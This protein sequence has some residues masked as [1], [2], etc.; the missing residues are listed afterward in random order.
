MNIRAATL[1]DRDAIHRVHWAAFAEDE[2]SLVAQLAVDLLA[3]ETSPKIISL[4][5]ELENSIVGHVAFSPVRLDSNDNFRGFI[6]GPLGVLPGY[7]QRGIGS[8]LVERGLQ[9]MTETGADILFVYGDPTYYSRF[10]FSADAAERYH[11]PYELQYP[12]G[13][14]AI[15]FTKEAARRTSANVICVASLSSSAL[16]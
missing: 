13:W 14:Q 8:Q 2:R 9:M 12:Y 11:P 1:L 7:Q 5:A 10:G 4:V 6:L 3:E 15:A 16:W